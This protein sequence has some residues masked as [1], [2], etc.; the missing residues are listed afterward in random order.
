[1]CQSHTTLLGGITCRTSGRSDRAE[2]S[3]AVLAEG[4]CLALSPLALYRGPT[5]QSNRPPSSPVTMLVTGRFYPRGS[6]WRALC[7]MRVGCESHRA[8]PTRALH[9]WTQRES[10]PRPSG[11]YD[12]SSSSFRGG[13]V[14]P[15][16]GQRSFPFRRLVSIGYPT[17]RLFY[18]VLDRSAYWCSLGCDESLGLDPRSRNEVVPLEKVCI[19]DRELFVSDAS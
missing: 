19:L 15:P 3:S 8:E 13:S 10:N 6:A 2:Q 1:M 12:Q 17:R 9:E 16:P 18:G 7:L 5:E 14:P 4:R 11:L